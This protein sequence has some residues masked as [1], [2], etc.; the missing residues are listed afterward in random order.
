MLTTQLFEARQ[1]YPPA[2]GEYPVQNQMYFNK[3]AGGLWTSDYIDDSR[4]SAWIQWCLAENFRANPFDCYLLTPD[5]KARIYTID[6]L[7]DLLLLANQFQYRPEPD[8][9]LH[10]MYIDF[11]SASRQYDA[12]HL[13]DRG[14]WATRLSLD[15][16][17]YG[18]DCESTCWFR[19]NF[20]IQSIGMKTF[21]LLED[22]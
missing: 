21:E 13:T 5:P 17:L 3:P 10:S 9:R 1:H 22:D 12:I 15:C 14:Q 19:G 16:S 11:V 20:T 6:S 4:G 2:S 7:S 18:W 8:L